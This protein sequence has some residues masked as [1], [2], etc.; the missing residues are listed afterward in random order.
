[1]ASIF[2]A[3]NIGYSGLKTSQ[4]AID[5][6]GHNIANAQNPDYTR[7][8]VVIEPN[9]PLNTTPG[10]IGLGA[11]ITEIVRVHDEFVY[12]R[13]KNS[14]TSNE[15]NQLRQE[16]MDEISSYFP[17]IDKNGIYNGMQDYFDAWNDFSKNTDDSALKTNLAQQTRTFTATI[18]DTR[19]QIASV[20]TRLDDQLKTSIDEINR[21]GKQIAELNVRINTD[22]AGGD[23]ANDLRDQRDKLELALSKLVDIAV[24]KGEMKPDMTTDRHLI[25]SGGEYHL[26]IG[27]S[28]FV[29][30]NTFHPLVL[31]RPEGS[32]F[33]DV[34]YQRQDYVK[35]DITDYIHGGKVGAILSL[36]DGDIQQILDELDSFASSLI[37]NTNN[38]YAAHATT[39]MSGST[40]IAPNQT[41]PESE[42]PIEEGSFF[43]KIYDIDGNEVA[44]RE[45]VLTPEMTYGEIAARIEDADIDDNGDNLKGNDVDN[46]LTASADGTFQISMDSTKARE[47]YTFA[48]EEAD[49]ENPTLFAGVLGLE[50]FFDGSD[51]KNITLNKSLDGNPTRIGGNAAPISGDNRMANSMIE[52]QYKKID[53]YKPADSN[54]HFAKETLSGFFRMSVTNVANTTAAVHSAAETSQSLLNAVVN[55][56]DSISK[57]DLDEELTNL[58]KYQTGYGAS[59]KVITTIDQMI[60]TLLG[61]KQ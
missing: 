19:A 5:T 58:M 2:N 35:F 28:S 57:V 6:T 53:F 50:R 55:E 16:T 54:T 43:V 11:K 10:D 42:L 29:D 26:S 30:G 45:I 38:L 60:Q 44:K 37:F 15:Y 3:L 20:Q 39:Q 41:I 24:S 4:I 36:R 47:G 51:A 22:E 61:I 23:N 31:D 48:I 25:E 40:E 14:S 18:R 59:A 34:Y 1:M 27:G 9:T 12:K 33:S 8:R 17:E 32:G 52:L 46:Y 56:F 7:Q 49:P 21:L 13:L